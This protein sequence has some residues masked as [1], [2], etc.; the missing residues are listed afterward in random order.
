MAQVWIIAVAIVI[1]FSFNLLC[2]MCNEN[3]IIWRLCGGRKGLLFVSNRKDKVAKQQ[4]PAT[5]FAWDLVPAEY[6]VRACASDVTARIQLE[7]P[8]MRVVPSLLAVQESS[9]WDSY[10]DLVPGP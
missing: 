10:V 9:T 2:Y 6:L 5:W 7:Q 1:V 8:L 3:S 4:R